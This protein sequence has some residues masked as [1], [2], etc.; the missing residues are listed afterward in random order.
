[1]KVVRALGD[2]AQMALFGVIVERAGHLKF[3]SYDTDY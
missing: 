3:A 2:T 1:V